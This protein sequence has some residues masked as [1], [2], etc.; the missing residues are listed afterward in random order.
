MS[1][2]KIFIGLNSDG[3]SPPPHDGLLTQNP[4]A[5]PWR[6]SSR[7]DLKLPSALG[8]N[9]LNAEQMRATPFRPTKQMILA[10]NSALYLRRPLL[11]TGK[12]GT[13]KSTLISKV[14]Y[15][16]KLGPV[17]RWSITSRS[18]VKGGAYEYDAVGRLQAAGPNGTAPPVESYLTLGPLGTALTA[19]S[20]P[21]PLLIDEIDKADLDLANDLLNV[22]EEGSYPIP[23]LKRLGTAEATVKDWFGSS[24]V[25]K[26][27]Q[28]E[29]GQFPFVVMTSNAEREFPPAFLR[30]C[31]RLTIEQPDTAELAAIVDSHLRSY[32]DGKQ[33]KQV[34]TL[35]KK[36]NE[37]AKTQEL[38][39]DQLLNAVFLTIGVV[40]AKKRSMS[41]SD[42]EE[43]R[44]NL[45]KQLTSL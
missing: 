43:L 20:W 12:P 7:M 17:L 13:G 2:W 8:P 19:E 32:L 23:E 41:K 14:A 6:Q 39:T 34:R 29:C 4:A 31:I 5:P 30:R 15:E 33:L 27:G 35:I 40:G 22:I 25:V 10:V 26:N 11:L 28:I 44:A 37:N 16:L 24:V 18:T 36:F 9:F 42:I 21:R 3:T 45:L 38:A 1:D